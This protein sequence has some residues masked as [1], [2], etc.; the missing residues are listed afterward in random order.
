MT[1][2]DN[3]FVAAG[4]DVEAKAAAIWISS[5]GLDRS[6]VPH[7]EDQFGGPDNPLVAR[8]ATVETVATP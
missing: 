7:N 4:Y 3:G 8:H 5:D 6:R 1:F 2:G